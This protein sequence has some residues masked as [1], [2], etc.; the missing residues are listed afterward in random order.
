V[1]KLSRLL[2]VY[3]IAAS[4]A[5][6]LGYL[7]SSPDKFTFEVIGMLLFFFALPLFLRWH[8]VLLI[9]FWNAVFNAFFLP[10][11]PDF[12][13][14]FAAVSFGISFLNHVV[15]QKQFLRAPELTCPIIF[16]GVV[17]L[18][19]AWYRGGI[20]I[21]SLG[22]STYGGRYYIYLLGAIAGYF[23]FTAE[24]VPVLKGGKMAGLFFLS[25]TSNAL[26][27]LI[28]MAGPAFYILYYFVPVGAASVQATSEYSSALLTRIEGLGPACF[29]GLCFLMARYGVRGLFDWSKPWRFMLLCLTIGATFFAGYRSTIVLL[30]LVFAFQFYFEGLMRTYFL[31][32][33]VGLA[34][35]GFLPIL[36]FSDSMPASVQRAISFLPVNVNSEILENA[37][38]SS[39]WRFHMWAIVWKEVPKY[40]IIGKGY[41]IDP[42]ELAAAVEAGRMG[43]P[44]S[45]YIG[46]MLAGDYHNGPFS[47]LVPFGILGMIGFIWVLIGGYR[48]LS[49]NHRFG[50]ARLRRVNGVLLSYYLTYCFAFFFIFGAFSSELSIFLGVCGLS[51]SLNGGVKRKA[52][53]ERK[54]IPV[55]QTLAMEPG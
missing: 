14:V 47:V 6:I 11:K 3:L 46:T 34:I 36:F 55:P 43:E 48:I 30:F 22:G 16:L 21:R 45:E 25:G 53:P 9:V 42:N 52:A 15:F 26:S 50:D 20:G 23:A 17:I 51:V 13:I 28:Y 24:P 12:W 32:I 18:A 2:I 44:E 1:F 4:L 8:H 7:V 39:D 37:K 19:T 49:W 35:G 38:A 29:A 5:L 27:N 40:L 33:I 54:S 10:G 41:S 31:P